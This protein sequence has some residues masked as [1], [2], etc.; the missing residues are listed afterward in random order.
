MVSSLLI[1]LSLLASLAALTIGVTVALLPHGSVV[2]GIVI[3]V[4]AVALGVG[5]VQLS[6]EHWGLMRRRRTPPPT[7]PP[8]RPTRQHPRA[9]RQT[10]A[11]Q[12]QRPG[13]QQQKERIERQRRRTQREARLQSAKSRNEEGE[14]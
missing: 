2:A 1:I 9:P 14:D 12:R 7:P 11:G 8:A 6:R 4:L 3:A 5:S 10:G 13:R